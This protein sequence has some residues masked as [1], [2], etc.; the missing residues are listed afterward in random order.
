MSD[1][2]TTL[3]DTRPLDRPSTQVSARVTIRHA[4]GERPGVAP[5]GPASAALVKDRLDLRATVSEHVVPRL[6]AA[7]RRDLASTPV[8]PGTGRLGHPPDEVGIFASRMLAGD[9]E[10]ACRRVERM[11]ADGQTL[12]CLFLN[13][14][15]PTAHHLRDLWSNDSCG[16]AD[17]TVALCNLQAV[18]RR[19][20]SPFGAD[21][22]ET[23]RRALI[24]APVPALEPDVGLP[25]FDA[26]LM[27]LFY[28]RE[29]WQ[30]R[31]ECGLTRPMA[32]AAVAAEW[33]DL[34]EILV[35]HE[36]HIEAVASTIRTI[37]RVSPNPAVGVMVC[38]PLCASH[39][40]LARALGADMTASD[41]LSSLA[42]A[43]RWGSRKALW[44]REGSASKPSRRHRLS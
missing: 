6:H 17:V 43:G 2:Q 21:G 5:A 23:G 32:R 38:G 25:L 30:A 27:A 33:F 31:I 34:I 36:R 8:L 40:D 15:A 9:V 16:L 35:P 18:L 24:L 10:A 12:E 1:M 28:R 20:A 29:G 14:L 26:M 37:R 7:L 13:L 39:P 3:T 22:L 19:Y 11:R 44:S 4:D 41:P 42:Q